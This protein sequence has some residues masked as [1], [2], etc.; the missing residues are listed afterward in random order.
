MKAEALDSSNLS[1]GSTR[2]QALSLSRVGSRSKVQPLPTSSAK[3]PKKLDDIQEVYE[4]FNG[5]VSHT[6]RAFKSF[7]NLI[8]YFVK[9]GFSFFIQRLVFPVFEKVGPILLYIIV[10]LFCIILFV[11]NFIMKI[12]KCSK[13]SLNPFSN[14]KNTQRLDKFDKIWG[15]KKFTLVM[16]LHGTLVYASKKEL[17]GNSN[18]RLFYE[19]VDVQKVGEKSEPY[20]VYPRPGLEDFLSTLGEHFNL[21][22]FSSRSQAISDAIIDQFDPWK[23]VQQRFYKNFCTVEEQNLKKDLTRIIAGSMDTVLALEDGIPKFTQKE[24][25][26]VVPKWD[27]KDPKDDLLKVIKEILVQEVSK[28]TKVT[29][30]ISALKL[31]R[32]D[33]KLAKEVD[34]DYNPCED[35]LPDIMSIKDSETVV[36]GHETNDPGTP[37]ASATDFEFPIQSPL[38]DG[39][40][41]NMMK[42]QPKPSVA[43]LNKH[44]SK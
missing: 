9:F 34:S 37:R 16:E 2:S 21:I 36:S 14:P 42:R 26:L 35:T 43:E 39:Q 10:S 38:K 40:S 41:A 7:F 28:A 11:F 8:L 44:E 30:L 25:T 19:K 15:E 31:S 27:G 5:F 29:D 12:L 3:K 32:E 33:V 22:I 24:N 20:F 13:K 6:S 23:V 4:E 18:Q 1:V 17:K